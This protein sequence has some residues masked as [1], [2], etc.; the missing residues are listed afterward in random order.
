M[1]NHQLLDNVTHQ[2]V[3]IETGFN[4]Q[5]ETPNAFTRVFLQEFRDVQLHYPIFFH[6]TQDTGEFEPI[7][8]MGF[9]ANENVFLDTDGWHADY[10]P[11]SVRRKPFLIGYQ[12]QMIDGMVQ[13]MPVVFIDMN[14]PRVGDIGEPLFLPEGGK[15]PYLQDVTTVL[16][17]VH[18]GHVA[19]K[20]FIS[21]LLEYELLES[22]KIAVTLGDGSKHTFTTLYTINEDALATLSADA[23]A[24][25]HQQGY[26]MGIHMCIASV[27]HV[28]TLIKRK[29]ELLSR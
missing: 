13:E 14:N 22:V 2:D 19:N 25:L 7:A 28:N 15:S 1:A 20:A 26:W 16:E 8:L 17:D 18:A 9:E 10:I 24:V 12:E 3:K 11:L 27:G 21:A 5:L 4:R 29:N 6:K 23:V